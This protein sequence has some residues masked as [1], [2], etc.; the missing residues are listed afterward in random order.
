MCEKEDSVLTVGPGSRLVCRSKED[1]QNTGINH[2]LF[3]PHHFVGHPQ[4]ETAVNG[5][6]QTTRQPIGTSPQPRGNAPAA[7]CDAVR[8]ARLT[9]HPSESEGAVRHN[10][11]P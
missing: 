9:G 4:S 7:R 5:S 3:L 8:R 6:W 1:S 11:R 10:S 2:I